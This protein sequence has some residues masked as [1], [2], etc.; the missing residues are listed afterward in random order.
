M[1]PNV[2][3]AN[4]IFITVTGALIPW[5]IFFCIRGLDAGVK[6]SRVPSPTYL[7]AVFILHRSE[8][9]PG[10]HRLGSQ[11]PHLCSCRSLCFKIIKTSL[12]D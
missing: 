10:V 12:M 5:F 4:N 6:Q 1:R 11:A 3:G 7:F 2:H 9:I 8:E